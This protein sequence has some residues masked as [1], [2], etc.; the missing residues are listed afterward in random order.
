MKTLFVLVLGLVAFVEILEPSA[1]APSQATMT[2]TGYFCPA[3]SKVW[4]DES[5]ALMGKQNVYCV[6]R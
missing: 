2:K 3:G 4:M 1:S 5:E 6:N